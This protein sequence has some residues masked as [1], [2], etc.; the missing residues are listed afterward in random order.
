MHNRETQPWLR[1]VKYMS[2]P[3]TNRP[4]V[5]MK[6]SGRYFLTSKVYHDWARK[7]NNL[8]EHFS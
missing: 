1:A 5:S 2:S 8:R 3:I 7:V 6:R 4:T